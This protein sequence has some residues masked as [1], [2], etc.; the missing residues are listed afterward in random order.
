[1][2]ICAYFSCIH[3]QFIANSSPWRTIAPRRY[4]ERPRRREHHDGE[5]AHRYVQRGEPRRQAGRR[6]LSAGAHTPHASTADT[7]RRRRLVPL[8]GPWPKGGGRAP[9]P[10]R[11]GTAT[12]G[13]TLRCLS[14]G[15]H[16]DAGLR[17]LRGTPPR[18]MSRREILGQERYM[19]LFCPAPLYKKVT[20]DP[21][22][23][24]PE[25]IGWERP[26]LHVMIGLE[27]GKA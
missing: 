22:P 24:E 6:A 15:A 26:I 1:L 19:N 10:P 3:P 7:A 5:A 23:A 4:P 9:S 21:Q 12:R 27:G 20:A 11:P 13:N 14:R 16:Q 18:R 25:P 17:S 2:T 8:G